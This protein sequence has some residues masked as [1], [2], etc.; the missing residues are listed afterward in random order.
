MYFEHEHLLQYYVIF[1]LTP[2]TT[3]VTPSILRPEEKYILTLRNRSETTITSISS[4]RTPQ[5]IIHNKI[6]NSDP[7]SGG[8]KSHLHVTCPSLTLDQHSE[9]M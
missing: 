1:R 6:E 2:S 3:C 8:F 9:M 4:T 7:L 5:S